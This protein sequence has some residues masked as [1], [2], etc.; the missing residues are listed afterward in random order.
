MKSTAGLCLGLI[1]ISSVLAFVSCGGDDDDAPGGAG[2]TS[3]GGAD[4]GTG[5]TAHAGGPAHMGGEAHGGAGHGDAATICQVLGHLCHDA[6]TGTGL[7]ADC[8][9]LGHEGDG[10]AC[11]QGFASCIDTCV[12][13]AGEGGAGG[14]A[15]TQQDPYCA[16]L[17][18]LCHPVDMG[19]VMGADCHDTSGKN[20]RTA[21]CRQARKHRRIQLP[22]PRRTLRLKRV[23]GVENVNPI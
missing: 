11:E 13:S 16:A 22:P 6:D 12:D 3:E 4:P 21:S 23:K 1:S 14:G 9:D 10:E 20:E 8:H 18:A 19:S 2:Q 7:A 15:S 17:G 5:G